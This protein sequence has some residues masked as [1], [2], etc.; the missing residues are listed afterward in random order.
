MSLW[1]IVPAKEPWRAKSRLAG[2][3]TPPRRWSLSMQLLERTL[4]AVRDATRVDRCIVIS[5]AAPHLAMARAF[6]V[7][8]VS[9]LRGGQEDRP[10]A[11]MPASEAG[12][13]PLNAAL[14]QAAEVA[15]RGGATELLILHADLVRI[16]AAAIDEMVR[17]LPDGPAVILAPD[18]RHKG[19]NAMLLRPPSVIPFQFGPGSFAAHQ[20]TA[21][22]LHIPL[23]VHDNPALAE[24]IDTPDDL[25][26]LDVLDSAAT[27]VAHRP[28]RARGPQSGDNAPAQPRSEEPVC[29][30]TPV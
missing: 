10:A 9:E 6:G 4:I 13:D 3:L 8:A 11:S 21:D 26:L 23:V 17:T 18:R 2:V 12:T 20:R 5:K 14:R 22:A 19:T 16:N 28:S 7:I 30:T 25:T 24:D 15:V 29:S 27:R 1:V